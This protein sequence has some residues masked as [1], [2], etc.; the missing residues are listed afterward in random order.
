MLNKSWEGQPYLKVQ[1]ILLT[2]AV[3]ASFFISCIYIV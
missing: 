1:L 3:G 2:V